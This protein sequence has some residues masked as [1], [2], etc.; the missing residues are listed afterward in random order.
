MRGGTQ[1]VAS[2]IRQRLESP[3]T[4][5]RKLL[6]RGEHLIEQ[7]RKLLTER[8]YEVSAS[9]ALSSSDPDIFIKTA[10]ALVGASLRVRRKPAPAVFRADFAVRGNDGQL[11]YV[12]HSF[13]LP[14]HS[15]HF[16]TISRASVIQQLAAETK[17]GGRAVLI[18]NYR[19]SGPLKEMAARAGIE[20]RTIEIDERA[21]LSDGAEELAN[22]IVA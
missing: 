3:T 2:R 9:P 17:D 15:L 16:A 4:R 20:I 14:E 7:A 19:E 8:G 10:A 1:T 13:G 5:Q 11:V 6:A 12:V 22:L 18:T 21:E